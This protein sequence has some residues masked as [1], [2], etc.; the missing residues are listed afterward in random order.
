[1]Q[2]EVVDE[3]DP[4]PQR[5]ILAAFARLA[6]TLNDPSGMQRVLIIPDRPEWT[7]AA[8]VLTVRAQSV[9]DCRILKVLECTDGPWWVRAHDLW[10][11][12]WYGGLPSSEFEP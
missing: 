11:S 5:A 2:W 10:G 7:S 9:F 6:I 1:V 12:T 4:N 8:I 3:M